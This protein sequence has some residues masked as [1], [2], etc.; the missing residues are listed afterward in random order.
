MKLTFKSLILT[1]ALLLLTAGIGHA[2][3]SNYGTASHNTRNWQELATYVGGTQVSSSGVFWSLDGG[4]T[5]GQQTDL[6][7]GDQIVFALNMHKRNLGTHYADHAK[8]WVDW[9][10][11]LSEGFVASDVVIS[12]S[13]VLTPGVTDVSFLS[14]LFTIT[15]DMVGD[16]FLRA[17]V[18]CS[19]SLNKAAGRS[20]DHDAPAFDSD[21]MPT[22]FLNQGEVEEWTLKVAATPLPPSVLMFGTGL[23]GFAPFVRRR[24]KK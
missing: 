4:T 13:Q 23:L 10:Q 7:V 14:G 24:F 12:G 8:L 19:S 15:K 20:V 3:P 5:W 6:K 2:L 17:R 16:L 18:V 9:D 1:S 11:D 21:F 22:G